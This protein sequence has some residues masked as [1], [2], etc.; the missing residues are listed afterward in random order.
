MGGSSRPILSHPQP[1]VLRQPCGMA[2]VG[3][4]AVVTGGAQGLGASIARRLNRDGLRV[5]VADVNAAG[6]KEL[7]QSLGAD[8]AALG[9][10]VDVTSDDSVQALMTQVQ[11]AYGR[12]DVLV[13]NAGILKRTPSAELSTDQWVRELDVNLG[14]TMRCSRAAFDLLRTGE[15]PSIINLGSV[16]STL[17]LPLRLAYST[18]KSGMLGLTRTLAAE[19]GSFGIRVN[20]IAP[21]YIDTDLMRS[22]FGEGVLDEQEILNRTPLRRLGSPDEIAN[23]ASFLASSDASFVTGILLKADGGVTIDGDFRPRST[24]V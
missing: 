12:L 24:R 5:V 11:T 22:G 17:G 3:R 7:A 10:E 21:G 20:A 4:V 1:R 9:L 6:A 19:W 13:N 18:A 2:L 16:G 14:G 23:V 8:D 15:N